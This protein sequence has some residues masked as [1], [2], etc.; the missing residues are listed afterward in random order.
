[1]RLVLVV[2]VVL[3]T[4]RQSFAFAQD[5]GREGRQVIDTKRYL[6]FIDMHVHNSLF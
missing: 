2:A 1:M 4:Q 3:L 6:H 5:Q